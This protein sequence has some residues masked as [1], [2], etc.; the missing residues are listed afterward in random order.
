MQ[1]TK[2]APLYAEPLP[3]TLGELISALSELTDDEEEIVAAACH[4]I[5]RGRIR[6]I[7]T[8]WPS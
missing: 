5:D 7:E 2:D 8:R 1:A 3:V 4:M 6:L